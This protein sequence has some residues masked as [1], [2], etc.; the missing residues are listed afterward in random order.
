[1]DFTHQSVLSQPTVAALTE[2]DFKARD[3][4][5]ARRQQSTE[6]PLCKGVYVDGTFGRGGH[7]RALLA[8]LAPEARLFVFDKDPAAIE[9]AQRLA[10]QD[11]RVTVIHAGFSRL[12]ARLQAHDVDSITGIM[13]DLG[14]SSPQIDDASRGFSFMRDGPLDMRMDTSVGWTARQWLETASLA[15]IT[16]VIK[17]YGEERFAFKIAKAIVARRESHP[18]CTT[19]DLAELVAR[20]VRTRK[21]GHHPATRTFQAIRIHLNQEL[22]E[23]ARALAS[24]L[25]LL[26]TGGRM[27]VISFHS[28]EDRLVKQTI[29]AAARPGQAYARLPIPERDMPQPVL[30]ALGRVLPHAAEKSANPRARSA[31][32]RVAERTATPLPAA[33]AQHFVPDIQQQYNLP[34]FH[35]AS[36]ERLP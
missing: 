25:E 12:T 33:G 5:A 32:L 35:F 13:L 34:E 3:F 14:V 36:Q 10:Q 1:M 17:V 19:R 29:M 15:E 21:P 28:L 11:S 26:E 22:Q 4:Q 6:L 18:L 7:A 16:E 9:V 2:G 24:T 20:V 8:R 30:K 27:A 23:L 31:V